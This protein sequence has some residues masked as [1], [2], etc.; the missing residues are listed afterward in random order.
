MHN[1]SGQRAGAEPSGHQQ[2]DGGPNNN[3]THILT[4]RYVAVVLLL[5]Q[6]ARLAQHGS[7]VTVFVGTVREPRMRGN[8]QLNHALHIAAV[9]QVAHD[10]AGRDYYQRKLAETG[11]KK[12]A[13]R[14]LKR[15]ISDA[16]YA[17]LQ[18]DASR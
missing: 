1:K 7:R 8:R 9:T 6:V 10:T 13:T 14:A 18:V 15:R 11:S 17:R 3:A 2:H 5:V 12:E 4:G 16:V